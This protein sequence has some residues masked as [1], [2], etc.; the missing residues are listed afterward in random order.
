MPSVRLTA[1]GKTLWDLIGIFGA[2]AGLAAPKRDDLVARLIHARRARCGR[3]IEQI[4]NAIEVAL[5]ESAPQLK[6]EHFARGF[7]MQEGC[8]PSYRFRRFDRE[9]VS[10]FMQRVT[11]V[12]L[13]ALRLGTGHKE[14][15]RRLKIVFVR[16]AIF[17]REAG[18]DLSRT[19]DLPAPSDPEEDTASFFLLQVSNGRPLS[20][21][22][23]L[24]YL[25][26]WPT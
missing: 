20:G 11:T 10:D 22:F 5:H 16:P 23:R 3:C 26:S 9:D 7:D 4:I 21:L 25:P 13:I 15:V 6:T 12:H 1:D 2:Q 19:T 18:M 14:V 17:R 8:A 24:G